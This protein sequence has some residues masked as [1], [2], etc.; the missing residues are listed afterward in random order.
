MLDT[1]GLRSPLK[2]A[3]EQFLLR[4]LA[5][6][7]D[8][9]SLEKLRLG[10]FAGSLELKDLQVR[11]DALALLGLE[12]VRVRS[13]SIRLIRLSVP[14]SKLATG[15]L[16][17]RVESVHLEVE[18][19]EAEASRPRSEVVAEVREA[20]RKAIDLREAQLR[21]L[22]QEKRDRAEAAEGGGQG[23]SYVVKL[24]RKIFNN[25]CVDLSDL[26]VVWASQ[27]NGLACGAELPTLSVLSTDQTFREVPEGQEV[28]VSG[29]S[30]Y[31]LMRLRGL[32][33][34]VSTASSCSL[35]GSDYMLSPV[36]ADLKFAHV[37]SDQILR[38]RLEVAMEE[39]AEVTLLRS[40]VKHLQAVHAA[41][42]EEAARLRALLVPAEEER[43]IF[44]D[45][46]ASTAEY[47][48]LYERCLLFQRRLA[49]GEARPLSPAELE[50]LQLLED[51]LSARLLARQRWLV[52]GRLEALHEASRRQQRAC[53]PAAAPEAGLLQLVSGYLGAPP[54]S[55][56]PVEPGRAVLL[57]PEA[58]QQL[59]A[60]LEED[61]SMVEAVDL[62]QRMKFEFI[63]GKM[64]VEL[65]DDRWPEE[66]RR[67][68]LSL[69]LQE[70]HWNVDADVATDSLGQD[71]VAWRVECCLSYFR[72]LHSSKRK[73]TMLRFCPGA[74]PACGAAQEAAAST[75]L[76]LESRPEAGASLLR[77]LFR[78]EPLEV[79]LLP[80]A[81]EQLLEFVWP[82]EA[83]SGLCLAAPPPGV[84]FEDVV[85]MSKELVVA[86]ASTAKEVAKRVCEQIPGRI[87]LD[88]KVASP[89]VHV[90]VSG[91]G[92]AVFSL[93]EM[94][95]VMPEPCDYYDLVFGIDLDHTRLQS[96]TTH[97]ESFNML[98]PVHL[99]LDFQCRALEDETC[100][101]V[102]V[103]VDEVKLSLAPQA[104][105]ILLAVPMAAADIMREAEPTPRP[106]GAA[107]PATEGAPADG[108]AAGLWPT[109]EALRQRASELAREVLGED[110]G[111]VEAAARRLA[112]V[113]EK[114]FRT[115]LAVLVGDLDVSLADSSSP[116][117][118]LHLRLL[119]P[120]MQLVCQM[121]PYIVSLS[122][123]GAV[124]EAEMLN[125]RASEREPVVESF[126]FSLQ[127]ALTPTGT[128]D[129]A[130]HVVVMGLG[131][132]LLN[133]KPSMVDTACR[134]LPLFTSS[135]LQASPLR[136]SGGGEPRPATAAGAP[137][138]G[139]QPGTYRVAN[140]CDY[141]LELEL[142]PRHGERL[143]VEARPT[144]SSFE[145]LDDRVPS[146]PAPAL[147]VRVPGCPWSE[148]LAWEPGAAAAVPG[149]GAV[150][151]VL[152]V[153]PA[154][155][156]LLLGMCLRLH[157]RTDL[158]LALRFHDASQREVLMVDVPGSAV[159][160]AALLG[161]AQPEG[162]R[163]EHALA[164]VGAPG[165]RRPSQDG[166][167]VLLPNAVCAVPAAALQRGAARTWLSAR[168]VGRD[169]C[170]CDA[171][172]V[173]SGVACCL[174]DCRPAGEAA[175]GAS[176]VSIVCECGPQA[177]LSALGDALVATVMLRPVLSLMNAL[178]VDDVSVAYADGAAAQSDGPRWR[179]VR[180]PR[181]R[182]LD[183]YSPAVLLH[184]RGLLVRVRLGDG[185][186]WSD[187]ASLASGAF[188]EAPASAECSSSHTLQARQH[189]D[190]AAAAV[191]V[192]AVHGDARC[193]GRCGVR[194]SC[195]CW[196][197]DR[198]G[199]GASLGLA[200]RLCH[201]GADL[202]RCREGVS[203][204]PGGCLEEGLGLSL[205][206]SC[207]G[208]ALAER[209]GVHV[210]ASWSC[211]S[212][213]TPCGP[214]VFCLQTDDLSAED[215]FG[216]QCQVVTL[217]PRLVLTNAADCDLDVHLSGGQ[218]L[219]LA[220][221]QSCES[222]WGVEHG[223]EDSPATSLRFRPAG[224]GSWSGQVACSDAAAGSAPLA[225]PS[226]GAGA[227][228]FEAWTADVAPVRGA[229]AVSFRR[230]SDF[231]AECRAP[232][233]HASVRTL[234]A[235]GV[236]TEAPLPQGSSVELGWAQPSSDCNGRAVI[237]VIGGST[238]H[239][240]DI[241]CSMRRDIPEHRLAIVVAHRGARTVL[242]LLD[243]GDSALSESG[244][245]SSW[246]SRL[247]LRLG[248]LGVSLIAETPQPRELLFV[249]LGLLRAELRQ[250]E[251]GVQQLRL[252]VSEA[253]VDCQLPGR[254]DASSTDWRRD[255]SLGLL[256]REQPATVFA[257]RGEGGRPCL[258]LL[259][260]VAGSAG[261]LLLPCAEVAL[262]AADLTVDDGWVRP[263]VDFWG[264]L[265]CRAAV[266]P[267]TCVREVLAAAGRPIA[268]GYT[269]PPM[270]LVFQVDALSI[271]SVRL[272]VWCLLRLRGARFLP[273]HL[274]TALQ[275]LSLSGQFALDG[276]TLV[277]P[278]RRL[279]AHRGSFSDFARGL[280]SEYTANLL[281][282]A[283]MC[284]GKSSLLNL[285][286]VP[287]KI[288]GTA[289]SY[290]SDSVGLAAS[291]ASS[292]LD[293]C[294]L[295]QG[296]VARQR[297]LR[298]EKQIH[299]IG[300][301]VAEAGKSLAQGVEGLFD[302]V[303]KPVEGAQRNGIGGLLAG[304][305]RGVAGSF[306][307]PI[308]KVGQ[309]I[310]DVGSGVAAQAT[311]DTQAARRRRERS[312]QRPPRLLFSSHGLIRPWSALEA[313]VLQAFG[314]ALAAGIEEVIP[315]TQHGPVR[316]VLLLF[317][318][319]LLVAEVE[320][321]SEAHGAAA[322]WTA[323]EPGGSVTEGA[324]AA[325]IH[326]GSRPSGSQQRT[327]GM[328]VAHPRGLAQI[329]ALL[330][331][332]DE[333]A[334]KLLWQALKP[335]NT[336]VYGVQDLERHI[337]GRA[338]EAS[339]PPGSQHA[340]A[341][342]RPREL[343]FADLAAV[344]AA[345]QG[346]VVSLEDVRGNAIVLPLFAAPLDGACREGVAAGL[347]AALARPDRRAC[348]GDL[349]SALRAQRRAAGAR[350]AA[351]CGLG[352]E[353]TAAPPAPESAGG[354]V[355]EVWEVQRRVPPSGE[356]R[357]PWL[358]TDHELRW[359]WVDAAGRRHPQLPPELPCREASALC[360]PPCRLDPLFRWTSTWAV[361]EDPGAGTG[362]WRYGLLWSSA[363]WDAQP[364][365]F[366]VLRRRKWT[367]TFT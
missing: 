269:P 154:S 218:V 42:W 174:V 87:H 120:G 125:P 327:S 129:S 208:E 196:L 271:S 100:L 367:R 9:I 155:R 20:K 321:Q 243:S 236:T 61:A 351:S 304:V 27:S 316:T 241:R 228:G 1:A 182:R 143:V 313:A 356:W 341:R 128:E 205:R 12:G 333:A 317:P 202:P 209:A 286:R 78:F 330:N 275:V 108:V 255:N 71:S 111:A 14:W 36:S 360:S 173:G 2:A 77:L 281:S 32:G 246:V 305:G 70:A 105:Q 297:R 141:P 50:R 69:T 94:R 237:L 248:H 238:H 49:G 35:A 184:D 18:Q 29:L 180:L 176:S 276:A 283:G 48:R 130:L 157:N 126:P 38:M 247:E 19:I 65:I 122:L 84:C 147:R 181:L 365:L 24:A 79:H 231:V 109:G 233:V 137:A 278:S 82:P 280:L 335:I 249:H 188:A 210:P 55:R 74:L 315:L 359:R 160:D 288:W 270:P 259:L 195:P 295:D 290:L 31:K 311:P 355:L 362:G 353:A 274:R 289:V 320:V 91:L 339:R 256:Q 66:V 177:A 26:T 168:P 342:R 75:R 117:A 300:S 312:R 47:G 282:A 11:P 175:G 331:E 3:L 133:V 194:L 44:S 206:S 332:M 239:V 86:H 140:L 235:R 97:G 72:A 67:Q 185:A 253:R 226:D 151:E 234:D 328:Q 13:G 294:T 33:V 6:Y 170:F 146:G 171:V 302:V 135:V 96:T 136:P 277:L 98:Q 106:Q 345:A 85:D 363:T 337:S 150:A 179:E 207:G 148:P 16:R 43:S 166:S 268:E 261:E 80:G 41:V 303:R 254:V 357:C 309:A 223:D 187:T 158:A 17:A 8:G 101:D 262:D 285:P 219:R 245:Q 338:P 62:P 64:A 138:A 119:P 57:S 46:S 139:P 310:S 361:R 197:A 21:E 132:L 198:S 134:I 121:Y 115:T 306:V 10:V 264:Q 200:L 244:F 347:R 104:L 366:N 30:M 93:G 348:W 73:Q 23:A 211:L 113:R 145:S 344:T 144:G 229:L 350:A 260:Q 39:I 284:L 164:G 217:R 25:I 224:R 214:F 227:A 291:E 107:Q 323:T 53:G 201:R 250:L 159:C 118:W 169:L 112:E 165:S 364:G 322:P 114:Q 99:H 203:L 325:R 127:M 152:A 40:Q 230:G 167:V 83:P 56:P 89:I 4:H 232:G 190:G 163:A 292:L 102:Q 59:L 131:P 191:L 95:L 225:L 81:L 22:L 273:R 92:T 186:P 172:Q 308:S 346:D 220:A 252:A 265:T 178:P 324:S 314:P 267:G 116:V 7:V 76:V 45:V 88:V 124:L 301:G 257:N 54:P 34:R 142:R 354:G 15:K 123:D 189:A 358:A 183:L 352:A 103:R 298:G 199:L 318:Q 58:R 296:Y 287:L 68:L 212:W 28:S 334:L 90:P 51:A 192:E 60:D 258:S 319:R 329:P 307:K 193:R 149:G 251:E 52:H 263:L 299:S 221:G 110:A 204:L 222:H 326:G 293:H 279:P 266:S 156:L 213:S 63:L 272:T 240:G 37:P 340:A 336:L 349:R 216:A 153:G 242:S 161:W 5:P 162:A 343:R 215:L